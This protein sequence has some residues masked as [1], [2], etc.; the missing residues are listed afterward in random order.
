MAWHLVRTMTMVFKTASEKKNIYF[1]FYSTFTPCPAFG[2]F[3]DPLMFA[4]YAGFAMQ[5]NLNQ[6][7]KV[8]FYFCCFLLITLRWRL[9]V[10]VNNTQ[11]RLGKAA[12]PSFRLFFSSTQLSSLSCY[13]GLVL[14]K[15]K[16]EKKEKVRRTYNSSLS[17]A[18]CLSLIYHFVST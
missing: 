11:V 16:K 1:F 7:P 6:A 15:K 8:L 10:L 17:L 3:A 18:L 2:L 13:L 5:V 9:M 4:P 12:S 14:L